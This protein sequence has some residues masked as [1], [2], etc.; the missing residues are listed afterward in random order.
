[1]DSRAQPGMNDLI[2]AEKAVL[3]EPD[4]P[5][6]PTC[7]SGSRWWRH[8]MAAR[9]GRHGGGQK[10]TQ[11]APGLYRIPSRLASHQDGVLVVLGEQLDGTDE[12][13]EALVKGEL[14]VQRLD[15]EAAAAIWLFQP[16]NLQLVFEERLGL[17]KGMQC[18][19]IICSKVAAPRHLGWCC[20]A[21]A[22]M[23]AWLQPSRPADVVPQLRGHSGRR[24]K[25]PRTQHSPDHGPLRGRPLRSLA[26]PPK[27]GPRPSVTDGNAARC[28]V[29]YKAERHRGRGGPRRRP[30]L[31][32]LVL[33]A[34]NLDGAR[35]AARLL[36]RRAHGR[37]PSGK[38]AWR[39][40][41][42]WGG[43][44]RGLGVGW[45]AGQAASNEG[46]RTAGGAAQRS[47]CETAQWPVQTATLVGEVQPS[48]AGLQDLS[49]AVGE[50][51]CRGQHIQSPTPS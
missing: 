34:R 24:A 39:V 5:A 15:A 41:A 33:M 35:G 10:P 7:R 25:Q 23:A 48:E 3:P 8:R 19:D 17:R 13:E 47:R 31:V 43:G 22:T 30:Y 29:A 28:A 45:A 4:G 32:S 46:R 21:A 20:R 26:E 51:G 37:G 40:G 11:Q 42:P 18:A 50:L 1:M 36:F 16:H 6:S 38:S 27:I 44:L 9:A 49:N 14:A 12:H 2:L